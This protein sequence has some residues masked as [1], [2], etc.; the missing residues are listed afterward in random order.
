[1]ESASLQASTKE[2]ADAFQVITVGD[3]G[4]GK[5]SIVLRFVKDKF[6]EDLTEAGYVSDFV[7]EV[8]VS[9]RTVKLHIW[10][11]AGLVSISQPA[12][13]NPYVV[14]SRAKHV[15]VSTINCLLYNIV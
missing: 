11:T 2:D 1:M 10:D 5:T 15:Q 9:E 4:V 7:K 13:I 6:Y 12:F 14:M 8:K 3:S